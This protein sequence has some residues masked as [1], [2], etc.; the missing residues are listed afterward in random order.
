[1]GSKKVLPKVTLTINGKDYPC[2]QTLGALRRFENE[3]GHSVADF[4]QNSISEQVTL[5][6]CMTKSACNKEG[7]PF[8]LCVDDFADALTP[9]DLTILAQEMTEAP[10]EKKK[11]Q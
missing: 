4:N 10:D 2:Y 3:T 7:I 5:L 11:A 1:M 6:Y 9:E 8:D